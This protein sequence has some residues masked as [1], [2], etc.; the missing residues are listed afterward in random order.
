[1]AD[2]YRQRIKDYLLD[3]TEA[4]DLIESYIADCSKENFLD[5]TEIQDSVSRRLAIIGEAANNLPDDF[6][7]GYPG[8]EWQKAADMRNV[9]VH[10]YFGVDLEIVWNVIVKV[11]P[12]FKKQIQE[13]LKSLD[14]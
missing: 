4:I 3:I 9:L 11:L 5:S 6:K 7:A 10:E 14:G 2:K 13:V 1:M 12:E 8:I